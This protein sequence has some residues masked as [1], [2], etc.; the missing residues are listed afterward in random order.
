MGVRVPSSALFIA[1]I[2]QLVEHDLAKVGVAGSNPVFRSTYLPALVVELVDTQDLKSCV[3]K[4]VRVQVPSEVLKT[5]CNFGLQ[6]VFIYCY[7]KYSVIFCFFLFLTVFVGCDRANE[8]N[9]RI[10]VEGKIVGSN[11]DEVFISIINNNFVIGEAR[12][13][14]SG[15]FV[16]SG[17]KDSSVSSLKLNKKIK[18]FSASKPGCQISADAYKIIIPN[19]I[20]YIVLNEII[21][22]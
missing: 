22:Q 7:M 9:S 5:L 18:S 4:D 17:P 12:P 14:S 19:E 15:S 1:K 21:L 2:A 10:Y 16:V 8:N 20:T 13:E 6:R 3:R 11:L